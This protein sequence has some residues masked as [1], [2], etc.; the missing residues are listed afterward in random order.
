MER[1]GPTRLERSVLLHLLEHRGQ[2]VRF[3]ADQWT[4][5]F[6]IFRAFAH[7]D[8]PE[9]K[10]CLRA[11]EMTRY[12]YRR[13]QYVIGYSEPKLVYS[14]T[15]SGHRKALDLRREDGGEESGESEI[16]ILPG[17]VVA[18]RESGA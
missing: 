4:T 2:Q 18:P 3:E 9:L 17:Q 14:L 8:L 5:E 12:I 13:V 6:G 11:L 1:E 15:P 7:E 10:N 16:A